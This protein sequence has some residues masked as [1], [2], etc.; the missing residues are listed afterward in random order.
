VR[1]SG[2]WEEGSHNAEIYGGLLGLSE[3]E[4]SELKAEGI[5]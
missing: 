1:W 5:L 3:E 4:Q 2:T